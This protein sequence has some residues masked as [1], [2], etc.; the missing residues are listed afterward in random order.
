MGVPFI[1]EYEGGSTVDVEL[2]IEDHYI[3][4]NDSR[5]KVRVKGTN[6]IVNVSASSEDEALEKAMKLLEK[7]RLTEV[8]RK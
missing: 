1:I 2:V 4:E 7:S 5:Y 8:L 3:L 6:I